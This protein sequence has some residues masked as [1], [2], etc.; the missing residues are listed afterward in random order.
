MDIPKIKSTILF[1]FSAINS[2]VKLILISNKIFSFHYSPDFGSIISKHNDFLLDVMFSGLTVIKKTS[3]SINP[4]FLNFYFQC[5]N[6]LLKAAFSGYLLFLYSKQAIYE[7]TL[8]YM[9]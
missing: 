5:T 4:N 1:A 9:F 6:V 2:N 8:T 3:G 7:N